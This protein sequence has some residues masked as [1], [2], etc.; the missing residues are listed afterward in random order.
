MTRRRRHPR[1]VLFR[2]LILLSFFFVFFFFLVFFQECTEECDT[3]LMG[4]F[5]FNG[6]ICSPAVMLSASSLP[7]TAP[8]LANLSSASGEC[9]LRSSLLRLAASCRPTTAP[10]LA[11]S[12]KS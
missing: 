7:R 4:D 1:L 3:C 5:F 8:A 6:I 11:K 12:S 2:L 10:A 9:D